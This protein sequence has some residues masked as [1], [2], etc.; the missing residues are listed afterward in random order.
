MT[1]TW[2]NRML[3]IL[4]KWESDC[5]QVA[6]EYN[7]TLLLDDSIDSSECDVQNSIIRIATYRPMSMGD[8]YS[9]FFH[10]IAH[11]W[12]YRNERYIRYHTDDGD[13]KYMHRIALRAERFVDKIGKK[14][15]S[16]LFCDITYLPQYDDPEDVVDL[17]RWLDK[18]YPLED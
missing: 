5:K 18:T 11:I 4:H 3:G 14:L 16:D 17:K 6:K 7:V 15:M 9:E 2:T 10:E 8:F 12:C 1:I 13:N